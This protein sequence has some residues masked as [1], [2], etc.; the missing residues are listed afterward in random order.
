VK[1]R[2][3]FNAFDIGVFAVIYN[4]IEQ[5][6]W[7]VESNLVLRRFAT[8]A[9]DNVTLKA[10]HFRKDGDDDGRLPELCKSEN[11]TTRL[12]DHDL[13]RW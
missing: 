2:Y 8:D 12:E 7:L 5:C 10:K 9:I 13:I 3:F 6:E 11:D 1:T 4:Q